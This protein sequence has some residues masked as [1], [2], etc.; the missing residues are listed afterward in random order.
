M[1]LNF[2]L[3]QTHM[4]R[5]AAL[6]VTMVTQLNTSIS[7]SSQYHN[8]FG[9]NATG[10]GILL[11]QIG[12]IL[13]SLSSLKFKISSHRFRRLRTISTKETMYYILWM[14][15]FIFVFRQTYGHGSGFAH[16]TWNR[17]KYFNSNP[18]NK[19]LATFFNMHSRMISIGKFINLL[20]LKSEWS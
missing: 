11:T 2:S 6:A 5:M 20:K 18:K 15:S 1:F 12:V 4:A 19:E 7:P 10:D 14:V 8:G 9:A 3:I 13:I 17:Q 16:N